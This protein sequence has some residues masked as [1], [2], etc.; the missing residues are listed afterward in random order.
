M[1]LGVP[2]SERRAI[3]AERLEGCGDMADATD[4]SDHC[5]GGGYSV[6]A[7]LSRLVSIDGREFCTFGRAV[8]VV[9]IGSRPGQVSWQSGYVSLVVLGSH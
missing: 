4:V 8:A 7:S 9:G 3:E 2:R 5:C 6:Y 1:P